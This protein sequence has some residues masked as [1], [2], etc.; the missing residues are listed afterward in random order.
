M[1]A[2]PEKDLAL[3]KIDIDPGK[4]HPLPLGTSSDLEVGLKALAI[5]NPFVAVDQTPI[6]NNRDL[7]LAL[8]NYKVSDRVALTVWRNGKDSKVDV[9]LEVADR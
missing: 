5:G 9:E 4:L 1:G 3:L 7:L 8:E 2:A 6:R